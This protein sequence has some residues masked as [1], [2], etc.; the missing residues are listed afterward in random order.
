MRP[1]RSDDYL[2]RVD[3]WLVVLERELA[4]VRKGSSDLR[5]NTAAMEEGNHGDQTGQDWGDG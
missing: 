4:R 3:H 2:E 1:R 5:A